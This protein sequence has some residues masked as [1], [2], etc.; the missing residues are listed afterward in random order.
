MI[1]KKYGRLTVVRKTDRKLRREFLYECKCSCGNT[2]YQTKQALEIG[3]VRSCGCL[4]KEKASELAKS[5]FVDG[6]RPSSFTGKPK[7]TNSTGLLGVTPYKQSGRTKYR[8]NLHYKGTN[9]QKKG[10]KT[11]EEAHEYRLELERKYL[12]PELRQ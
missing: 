3:H 6:T 11:A 12:P 2:T 1:G 4:Q 10:F 9:Y 8:A 7:S 5:Q